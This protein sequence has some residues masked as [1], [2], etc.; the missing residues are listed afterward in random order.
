[1]LWPLDLEQAFLSLL[2]LTSALN[3]VFWPEHIYNVTK[4]SCVSLADFEGGNTLYSDGFLSQKLCLLL[5][6]IKHNHS[7]ISFLNSLEPEL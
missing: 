1:M 2:M 7:L 6:P 4:T 3:E 5:L